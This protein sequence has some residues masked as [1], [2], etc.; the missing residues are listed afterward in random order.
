MNSGLKWTLIGCGA[1]CLLPLLLLAILL[2]VVAM[3]V[4]EHKQVAVV[5][6]FGAI[7]AASGEGGLLG[8][9]QSAESIIEQLRRAT[10]DE[11]VAAIVLRINSPGGSAAASQEIYEQV[12]RSARSKPVYASLADV[13]ASGGYY[14]AAGADQIYANPASI[15]GSIGVIF[16][17]ADLSG[18]LGRLGV[19]TA[20]IKSGKFK[21]MGSFA[22]SLSPEERA[23]VQGL[24]NDTYEQFLEAVAKGRKLPVARVRQLADGRIY[25]GRQALK[26]K[27]V[28]KIGG[29][30]D[31]V[32]AVA[33]EA[34]I[35]GE[36]EVTVYGGRTLFERLFSLE[37]RSL[38]DRMYLM[39]YDLMGP[40]PVQ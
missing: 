5:N 29:L 21:D 37:S 12:V 27:L 19:K 40:R 10:E 4:P 18:L 24:I 31:T 23:L 28:D 17:Q 20:V 35:K 14:I 11:Q 2:A 32:E 15:T 33:R 39:Y 36:P 16:M 6:V 7:A 38:V 9:G 25:S 3:A 26:V 22:R 8:G 34:G 13:A 30:Q 1:G